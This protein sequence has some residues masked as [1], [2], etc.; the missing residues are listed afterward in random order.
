MNIIHSQAKLKKF[1]TLK[2]TPFPLTQGILKVHRRAWLFFPTLFL[3][4]AV[5]EKF[6][7]ESCN[8][9]HLITQH[10]NI[11]ART[12]EACVGQRGYMTSGWRNLF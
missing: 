2:S 3:A 9:H 1:W 5:T 7:R 6:S 8:S 4:I 10:D 12:H 11:Q